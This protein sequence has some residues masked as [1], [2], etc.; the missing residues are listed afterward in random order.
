MPAPLRG[1]GRFPMNLLQKFRQRK[2]HVLLENTIMLYILTFSNA[3]LGLVTQGYQ[4][5]VLG[6]EHIGLLGAANYTTNF[7]QIFIDFGF[8]M[9]ATA[10]ISQHRED[11]K[12]LNKTLTCVVSAKCFF[13]VLSLLVLMIFI[14]PT[15]KEPGELLAYVF[16]LLYVCMVALLPD[17]MYRGLEKMSAI[18]VRAVLVKVFATAMVFVFVKQPEDYY[19]VPLI[20]AIGN[21]GATLF[22]YWHLFAKIGLRFAKVS[23]RDIWLEI[24]DASQF[25]LSKVSAAINSNLNGILLKNVAGPVANG[26]YFNADKVISTARNGMSPISDSLYPHMMKHKNFKLVKKAM[27]YIYPIILAGCAFVFVLARPLLVWWLGEEVGAQVVLPLRLLIPAAVFTFPNYILGY[28]TL[29]AMGL[30]RYANISVA[31]GTAVYLIGVGVSFL[32]W[33]IDLVS[34]CVLTSLTDFAI[35]VFRLVVIVRN[36][37]LMNGSEGPLS[38]KEEKQP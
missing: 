24:K 21:A 10:K 34:L 9:S 18:T 32:T 5:R 2:P 38:E 1:A 28:P 4:T 20:S 16:Y 15:L 25:F 19:L 14:R 31:F 36:R 26:L 27:L 33:G 3:L 12:Y 37:H 11:K 30:A 17:F 8:I 7:F 6:A 23:F 35:L 29:G 22:V 13:M